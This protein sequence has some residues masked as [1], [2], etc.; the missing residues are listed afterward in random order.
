MHLRERRDLLHPPR[1]SLLRPPPHTH[2][3]LTGRHISQPQR[4]QLPDR[5][6]ESS[7]IPTIASR[8]AR[9]APDIPIPARSSGADDAM[10]ANPRYNAARSRAGTVSRSSGCSTTG[11]HTDFSGT[12]KLARIPRQSRTTRNVATGNG[13]PTSFT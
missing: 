7:T 13:L 2:R 5:H 9:S 4:S 1:G 6:P 3:P 11:S 8:R 12:T 10:S